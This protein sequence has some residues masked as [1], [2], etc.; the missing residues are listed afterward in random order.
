MTVEI[1]MAIS[2]HVNLAEV[3]SRA[4][5]R[6][7]HLLLEPS[8]SNVQSAQN[9]MSVSNVQSAPSVQFAAN[10]PSK[11]HAKNVVQLH[12][13]QDAHSEPL[14]R[15]GKIKHANHAP[16][17]R[18]LPQLPE[19]VVELNLLVLQRRLHVCPLKSA[20]L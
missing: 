7:R 5:R 16:A 2:N 13:P 11:R 12:K 17:K 14:Q 18:A 9:A 6:V 4:P 10:A 19:T 3:A 15:S 1:A 20:S 8:V